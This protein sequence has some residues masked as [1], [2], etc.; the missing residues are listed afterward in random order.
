MI[1]CAVSPETNWNA[2]ENF[3]AHGFLKTNAVSRKALIA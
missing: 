3:R 1:S 2:S